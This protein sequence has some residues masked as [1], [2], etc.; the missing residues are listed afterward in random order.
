M[1]YKV[2]A[3]V[4]RRTVLHLS[5][6][7]GVVFGKI[8]ISLLLGQFSLRV[9][10]R[11]TRSPE[12]LLLPPSRFTASMSAVFSRLPLAPNTFLQSHPSFDIFS[13]SKLALLRFYYSA[14]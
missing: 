3:L 12:F 4:K 8:E 11:G 6:L 2:D 7:Y 10:A 1:S 5:F 9:P 13:D 14:A